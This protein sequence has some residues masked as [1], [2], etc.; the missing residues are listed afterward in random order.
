MT[1]FTECY[2]FLYSQI[3]PF[4]SYHEGIQAPQEEARPS[5]PGDGYD[6]RHLIGYHRLG[7]KATYPPTALC[8]Y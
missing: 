1:F 5:L 6:G 7:T 3:S 2:D 4:L 8:P